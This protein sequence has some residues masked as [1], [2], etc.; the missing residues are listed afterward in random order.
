MTV[1]R[2]SAEGRLD[3]MK[4]EAMYI[5]VL[6]HDGAAAQVVGIWCEHQGR[7]RRFTADNVR[8]L[9]GGGHDFFVCDAAGEEHTI[10]VVGVRPRAHMRTNV[11]QIEHN[12]LADLP[13][14][15]QHGHSAG[16]S[17]RPPPD[18]DD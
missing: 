8:D 5:E 12:A 2:T 14:W 3:A 7:F 4:F 1:A 10:D 18:A 15:G 16:H 9:Q 6:P 11:S 13:D 17:T